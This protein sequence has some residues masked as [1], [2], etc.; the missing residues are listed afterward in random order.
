MEITEIQKIGKG[1]RYRVFVDEQLVGIFEAEILAKCGWKTGQDISQEQLDTW[2][3]ENG[4]YACFDRALGVLEKGMKT[5]KTIKDYL[6]QKGYPEI[7]IE[8]AVVKLKDYGYINDAVFAESYIRTYGA[9]K[10]SKKLKYDLLGKGIAADI[11]AEKL[12][13]EIDADEQEAACQKFAMKYIK[14]KD[15]DQKTKQKLYAHL[16]AKGFEFDLISRI[17]REIESQT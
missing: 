16:V 13:S 14:G 12:E 17:V 7:C 6:L 8:K 4:D 10:G 1:M 5:E 3:L 2:K 9:L 11:V 15:W